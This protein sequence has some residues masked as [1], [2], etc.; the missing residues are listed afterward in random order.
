MYILEKAK[1]RNDR[2]CD[3]P[4]EQLKWCGVCMHPSQQYLYENR[5]ELQGRDSTYYYR[6][7][8]M[9]PDEVAWQIR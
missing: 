2:G 9:K 1:V 4:A 5:I 7:R 8:E 3:I 6:V